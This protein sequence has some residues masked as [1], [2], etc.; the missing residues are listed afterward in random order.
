MDI[1]VKR[2]TSSFIINGAPASR[3]QFPLINAFALTSH[4]VQASTLP[5]ISLDLNSQM[6]EKG[7]AYVAISRCTNWNNVK[8]KSLSREAFAADKSVIKEY[9]RLETI[10]S[11]PLPLSRPLQNHN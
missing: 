6:F 4:K 11:Q 2:C 9:E 5:D 10:A 8:I 3:T 7:Q 1:I